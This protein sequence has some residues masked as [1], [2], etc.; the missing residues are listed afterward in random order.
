[1]IIEPNII[2]MIIFG[3]CLSATA[4]FK[5]FLPLL[6]ASILAKFGYLPLAESFLWIGSTPAIILF[7]TATVFEI[8]A[9]F[10]PFVD[11][12]LDTISIP[13]ATVIGTLL[14]VSVINIDTLDPILKWSIGVILGGGS[15]GVIKSANSLLRLTSSATTVGLA[16]PLINIFET[17]VSIVLIFLSIIAV[18]IFPILF[19]FIIGVLFL[20]VFFVWKKVKRLKKDKELKAQANQNITTN[21][22]INF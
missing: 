17:I 6:A 22:D 15:A 9:Y 12:L 20:I 2:L 14:T 18:L 7:T 1:M 19:V 3:I 4:G 16:N 10:I 13:L 8:F 5:V 21:T 11:N